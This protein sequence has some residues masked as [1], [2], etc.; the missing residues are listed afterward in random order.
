MDKEQLLETV[1]MWID[2]DDEIKSLQKQ[3]RDKKNTKKQATLD[4]VETMKSNEIDCFEIG[5]GNKLVYSKRK[6]KK[7][8]S[9]K[10]LLASLSTYF[11]GKPDQ[12]KELSKFIMSTRGDNIK[13]NIQRKIPK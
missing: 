6:T 10:H 13:E 1:K 8:L 7:P 4:L 2:L 11:K 5:S 9:K 12:V 3:I